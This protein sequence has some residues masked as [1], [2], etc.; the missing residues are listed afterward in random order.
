MGLWSTLFSI[1]V[2]SVF[3]NLKIF[4]F[5]SCIHCRWTI[6]AKLFTNVAIK[7]V[8]LRPCIMVTQADVYLLWYSL[9]PLTTK[10][11]STWLMT[12]SI[13]V[14]VGLCRYWQGN[15]LRGGPVMEVFGLEKWNEIAWLPMV[16]L[17][18]SK[19]GCLTKV[20]HIGSTFVN[21]VGW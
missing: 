21:D 2:I 5:S 6:S 11:W 12:R 14:G 15:R 10:D 1:T 4:I 17:T 20:M 7:C 8:A 18:F 16:L 3:W 19:R 9:A 13:H